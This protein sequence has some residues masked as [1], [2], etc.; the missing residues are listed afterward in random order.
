[1]GCYLGVDLGST[2]TKAI[3]LNEEQEVIGR[4]LTNTRSNYSV[5]CEVAQKEAETNAKFSF[6]EKSLKKYPDLNNIADTIFGKIELNFRY[7]QHLF[8]LNRLKELCLNYLL[9]N[10]FAGERGDLEWVLREIFT[11][12]EKE[13][14]TIYQE[15]GQDRSRFFRDIVGSKYM[16]LVEK[17]S[18]KYKVDFESLMSLY[19]KS[20]IHVE[21]QVIE[22]DFYENM[23]RAAD[24]TVKNHP[25]S[26]AIKES[27]IK[28]INEVIDGKLEIV[29]MVGTG[30]G[31]QQ[32]PFPKKNIRSEILCHGLGA[33]YMFPD[34]RTVL[35]IGGQDTKGIQ[36]DKDGIVTNFQ[37]NDRCAAGCGR[38]LGYIAEELSIGLHQLGPLSL[39]ATKVVK[40]SSTCTVFAGA[41]L[42]DMLSL[43]EKRENVLA[44]LHRSIILRVM[45]ILARSGGV[46]N[47]F[48][49]TGGVAKNQAVVNA[50]REITFE[51]YGELTI[52]ISSDSI[53]TGAVG[54]A[55]FA[56]RG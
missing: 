54:A 42:R 35:D 12:M 15:M 16:A 38:Y 21:N 22:I 10:S 39:K 32:L 52:N 8:K 28:A 50:L 36:V 33:H 53:Y 1:M 5:A 51:N 24:R 20:I 13:A 17:N 25:E 43:G 55:L 26:D 27:L 49:F 23:K 45:S 7:E 37:M 30:Y 40:V 14:Y 56:K 34:T 4:G 44:G 48:T 47:E 29:S 9:N 18:V 2:T 6:L 41:E 19:D 11:E 3:I 46:K 31:R